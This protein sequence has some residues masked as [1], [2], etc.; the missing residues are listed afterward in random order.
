VTGSQ[1]KRTLWPLGVTALMVLSGASRVVAA[2]PPA[3]SQPAR[4]KT[5]A[6]SFTTYL[7]GSGGELLRDMTLD[8]QGNIYV[9][10]IAGSADLPRTSGAIGGQSKGGGAMVAKSSPAGKLVWSKVVGGLGESSYF[11]GDWWMRW[12][13]PTLGRWVNHDPIGERG[14]WHL[15]G[16]IGNSPQDL[17]DPDGRIVIGISGW[18]FLWGKGWA[19]ISEM[20]KAIVQGVD[21]QLR[22]LEQR[23]QFQ[24]PHERF[25]LLNGTD[26]RDLP[27]LRREAQEY[28]RRRLEGAYCDFEGFVLF[29]YSD[30]A[31]T[32]YQWF[33]RGYAREDLRSS[34]NSDMYARVS[35]VGMIDQTR[36]NFDLPA[37]DK[38]LRKEGDFTNRTVPLQDGDL[39]RF[40]QVFWQDADRPIDLEQW[41]GY[42]HIGDWETQQY[43]P[44]R[45]MT[46]PDNAQLQR[47]LIDTAIAKYREDI[48]E[49]LS[50]HFAGLEFHR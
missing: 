27:R 49:Q 8:A 48:D 25:V 24:F 19:P 47:R 40:G 17:V 14:G 39:A 23:F 5:Y 20:G 30:G 46:I 42:I 50:Q 18:G 32:I 12:Y 6:L 26:G 41:R 43:S 31:M 38:E 33:Q 9:A 22:V 35:Y 2:A 21:S 15:Y 3:A 29:G 4:D 16:Y 34:V 37:N 36:A 11:Y 13:S 7:G 28:R 10:G 44:E 45:H 1:H